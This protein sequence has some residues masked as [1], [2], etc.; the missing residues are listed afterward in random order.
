VGNFLPCPSPDNRTSWPEAETLW[1]RISGRNKR[2]LRSGFGAEY[3]EAFD[4]NYEVETIEP[5]SFLLR[6]FWRVVRAI[7]AVYRVAQATLFGCRWK[8]VPVTNAFLHPR[9]DGKVEALSEFSTRTW[10]ICNLPRGGRDPPEHRGGSS[11]GR[12]TPTFSKLPSE[13]KSIWGNPRKTKGVS[14]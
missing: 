13:L 6:A 11:C 3:A 2:P 5:I 8:M 7:G 1:R 12:S 14:R 9:A 4:F 10:K